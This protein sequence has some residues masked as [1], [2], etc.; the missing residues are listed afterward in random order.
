MSLGEMFISGL[1]A[2]W[3][4]GTMFLMVIV[5]IVLGTIFGALPGVS[6]TMA[7][8]LGLTFTYTMGPVPAI[9]FLTA[10]YCSSITGGSITAILFKIP[11][12]P[13]S[14]PTT[15]DGYPMAQRGEAGKALG[16]ALMASAIGGLFSALVMFLL[17]AA[18][19]KAALAFG[20]GDLFAITFLGLSI[21]VVLDTEHILTTIISGLLGLLLACIGQDPM[22]GMARLTFGQVNLLSGMEMIPVLIGLFAVTEVLKQTG[23]KKRLSA[24][25]GVSNGRVN[26]KMPSLKELWSIKWVMLR[27]AIV[28]TIVGI[29]PG[30]GATIASFMCYTME[31]KLSKYPEKFGT[32]II[33]GIAASEAANNAATGGA[34]VPLLSLGIPGGNAAAVMASALAL[35]GV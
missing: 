2:V 35:K 30:A 4:G 16:V 7:V 15:F 26:T 1:S 32:G 8:A 33:D 10:I 19:S 5:A 13:S 14:A 24:E 21:L 31:N 12:V 29:L 34:M 23:A 20:Q 25:D 6:A 27:C 11:G 22:A 9:V 28:G 3:G 17:S 18:L